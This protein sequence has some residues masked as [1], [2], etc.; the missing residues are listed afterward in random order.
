MGFWGS[1]LGAQSSD[2]EKLLAR[3]DC[4]HEGDTRQQGETPLVVE[5]AV[6]NH[7]RNPLNS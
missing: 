3:G 6:S 7:R 5:G 2:V 4:S 1:E